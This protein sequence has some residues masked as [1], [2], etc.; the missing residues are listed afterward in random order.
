MHN[1]MCLKLKHLQYSVKKLAKKWDCSEYTNFRILGLKKNAASHLHLA[2][3]QH[4]HLQKELLID[5]KNTITKASAE[6]PRL[7]PRALDIKTAILL[8]PGWLVKY[9]AF[10]KYTLRA[11]KNVQKQEFLKC[12]WVS[13]YGNLAEVYMPQC[14][15]RV[16]VFIKKNPTEFFE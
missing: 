15:H 12:I 16:A 1:S 8:F 3:V 13:Q 7:Q 11:L 14:A 5:F 6:R 9:Q 2:Y 4:L 10:K